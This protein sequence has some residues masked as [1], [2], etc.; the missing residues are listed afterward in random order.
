MLARAGKLG[1]LYEPVLKLKQKL[2]PL[3]AL[4]EIAPPQEAASA[5]GVPARRTAAAEQRKRVM[6]GVKRTAS[7]AKSGKKD[8]RSA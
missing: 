3:E 5:A 4:R 6:A 2:P 7:R 1:D 8:R